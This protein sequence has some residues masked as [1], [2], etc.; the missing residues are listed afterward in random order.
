ME[1]T[2]LD[3]TKGR[4]AVLLG[5]NRVIGP[6]IAGILLEAVRALG[7]RIHIPIRIQYM[8]I[9]VLG[10]DTQVLDILI[11]DLSILTA[12]VG[13]RPEVIGMRLRRPSSGRRSSNRLKNLSATK[14]KKRP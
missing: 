14:N 8:L 9:V 7:M 12:V 13:I 2:Y 5:T 4:V 1:T 3:T 6:T 10:P 11:V